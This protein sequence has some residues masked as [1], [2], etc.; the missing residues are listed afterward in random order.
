MT[1]MEVFE[2]FCKLAE[3]ERLHFLRSLA[4]YLDLHLPDGTHV[5][6]PKEEFARLVRIM[7]EHEE[8]RPS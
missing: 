8:S 3:P 7:R 6:L 2:E 4:L 5:L 1:A